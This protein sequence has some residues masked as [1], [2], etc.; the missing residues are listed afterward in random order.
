MAN[1]SRKDTKLHSETLNIEDS[2]T[3]IRENAD[4]VY[5]EWRNPI[6]PRIDVAIDTSSLANG[7][8]AIKRELVKLVAERNAVLDVSQNHG[9]GMQW[10]NPL[11]TITW[12]DGTSIVYG[13]VKL[14]NIP[15]IIDEAINRSGAALH[16]GIGLL[17]G[18]HSSLVNLREHT[19]FKNEPGER[20]LIKRIGFTNPDS[21]DHYIGTRGWSSFARILYRGM[22]PDDVRQ[23]LLDG[24]L[25]GRGGGGFPAGMKWNFLAGASD[26]E[27]YMVCNADEGD[28]G[29]WVNR[30]IL[31][32]DPHLLLEGMAI[33][34]Y[35]TG[36]QRGF[37]YIRDEYPLGVER[38]RNAIKQ[39][40]EKG[41]L[42]SNILGSQFS[43][44]LEVVRGAGSYVCGEETGLL[45][46]IQGQRGQPRIRPPFPAQAGVFMKPSNV[47][48]VETFS[49]VPLVLQNGSSWYK[50]YG[51]EAM[52]GTRLF[53]FSGDIPYT[54]FMELPFGTPMKDVLESCGGVNPGEKLVAI[55]SGGP[56][57]SLVP[58][59]ALPNLTLENSSFVP[60]DAMMGSGGIVWVSD[61]THLIILNEYISEFV[62]EE[63]CGRCTTCH[64][65]N[66]RMTEI[67]RRIMAGNGRREDEFNLKMIDDTLQHSNCVHG[68]FSPKPMR[69]LLQHF[70][71]EYDALVVDRKDSTLTIPAMTQ[72]RITNTADRRIEDAVTI[73]PVNAFRG[74]VGNRSID[75]EA[76]IRC[77]ACTEI[78]P[79]AIV[80]ESRVDTAQSI[81]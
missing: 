71:H 25:G 58:A 2:Y 38:V 50:E 56:L 48:N 57:G 20:R 62:E 81:I 61:R 40:E 64:G 46:S 30:V 72:F 12:P 36:S 47:N 29:A 66:Q 49:H 28:P 37:I 67:F 79:N 43:F 74:E 51:T 53:S 63:S 34:A 54:G 26:S 65:G 18:D 55:Q 32:G 22:T 35:A 33:A 42:G 1:I 69:N 23:E 77:G 19:F 27:H 44:Q 78:A 15:D 68:Q 10:L 39:A 11:V 52:R 14:G 7:A 80:R 41:L 75:D 17:S 6:R 4:L 9:Y 59:S 8:L 31:E 70:R 76:C 73:C 13:P 21:I 24:G 45:S 3:N 5:S 16:L 60:Y